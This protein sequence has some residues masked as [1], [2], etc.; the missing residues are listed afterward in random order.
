VP[1]TAGGL[2]GWAIFYSRRDGGVRVTLCP[3]MACLNVVRPLPVWANS[4]WRLD[5]PIR[6]RVSAVCGLV[7]VTGESRVIDIDRW[8]PSL[9]LA[10]RERESFT[11]HKHLHR[12]QK[13]N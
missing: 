10:K 9:S 4:A 13:L 3:R 11:N 6:S 1:T 8:S 7:T 2:D 12:E 5:L